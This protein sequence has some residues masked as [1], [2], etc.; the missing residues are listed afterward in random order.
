MSKPALN[1]WL[2]RSSVVLLLTCMTFCVK[3]KPASAHRAIG[4]PKLATPVML[5]AGPVPDSA[6]GT[7]L[8]ARVAYCTRSS[9][10][11]VGAERRDQL[12][13]GRVL[14]IGEVGGA[15][16]RRRGRRRRWR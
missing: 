7:R 8:C 16:H 6:F 2:P 5:I 1:A 9:F 12:R 4:P 10:S 15:L 14:A 13:A 11:D 3:P